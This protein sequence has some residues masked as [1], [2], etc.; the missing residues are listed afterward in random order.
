L[1]YLKLFP[2]LP[3]VIPRHNSRGRGRDEGYIPVETE[4]AF[5][6]ESR[7]MPKARP[8]REYFAFSTYHQYTLRESSLA[9][10]A[11]T[12]VTSNCSFYDG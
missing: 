1:S 3:P 12:T 9:T 11:L 4:A 7:G 5:G 6:C 2:L 10:V 8:T